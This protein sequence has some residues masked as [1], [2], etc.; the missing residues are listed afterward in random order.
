MTG[1]ASTSDVTLASGSVSIAV[2]G[3]TTVYTKAV[4]IAWSEYFGLAY[5]AVASAGSPNITIQIEESWILPGIEGATDTNWVIP[6]GMS[7]VVTALTAETWQIK[8]ISPVPKEY[9][10]FK[11]TGNSGNNADTIVTMNLTTWEL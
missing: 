6:V 11:I 5:R 3:E 2:A 9:L 10:R 4:L 8:T 7:D 1:R